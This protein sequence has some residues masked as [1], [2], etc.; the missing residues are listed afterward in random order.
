MLVLRRFTEQTLTDAY[1]YLTAIPGA[2]TRHDDI[3]FGMT[4][5]E[6]TCTACGGHLGHVFKGEGFPT[7]SALQI[8]VSLLTKL[9]LLR[10]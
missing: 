9:E 6:I 5:T 1:S 3:S 4:R 8:V 2:V 10:I 7:P